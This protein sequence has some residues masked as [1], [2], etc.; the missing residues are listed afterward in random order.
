MS[1]TGKILILACMLCSFKAKAQKDELFSPGISYQGQFM[2]EANLMVYERPSGYMTLGFGGYRVG[3]E[4]N[5]KPND[6]II[7]PKLNLEL[8]YILVSARMGFV[9]YMKRGNFDLRFLPEVGLTLAGGVN[10]MYGYGLPLLS[11]RVDDISRHRV[12]LTVNLGGWIW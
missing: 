2:Y 11:N 3:L 7:A 8:N 1:Y 12:T 5:F 10:L 9:S 6:L 4:T